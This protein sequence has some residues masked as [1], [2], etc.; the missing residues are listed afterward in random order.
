MQKFLA[1]RARLCF[2]EEVQ[3]QVRRKMTCNINALPQN[4]QTASNDAGQSSGV[5][6]P[7]KQGLK[8]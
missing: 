7:E 8:V 4:G 6:K 3:N 2:P 5:E 1:V